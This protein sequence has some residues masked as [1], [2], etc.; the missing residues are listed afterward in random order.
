MKK[1]RHISMLIILGVFCLS[2]ATVMAQD[3]PKDTTKKKEKHKVSFKDSLDHAFDLSN[4]MIYAGGFVLVPV[5]ITEPALGGIG[6]ALVP[7]FLKQ[8]APLIDTVNGKVRIRRINPDI[9]GALAMYTANNSWMAG[10]FRGGTFAKPNITYRAMAAYGSLNLSFY[11][12]FPVIGEKE[13][14]F[15]FKVVPIYLQA[16][17][18][19]GNNNRWSAGIQYLFLDA[20]ISSKGDNMPDFVTSKEL[21]SI[22]SQ[23]GGVFQYD[24]RDNIF[25]PNKGVRLQADFFWSN[26]ILGSDY[27]SWQIDYSAIG[28]TPI[29]KKLIGG[30]RIEGQQSLGSPPFYTLPFVNLRGVPS[31]RYQGKATLQSEVETRWDFYKRWSAVFYGGTGVAY[32]KWSDMFANDLVYS[33][34][35][36]FRYLIARKFGLRMGADV[37]RG[38]EKWAYYIVF[39]SSW[40]R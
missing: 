39:G 23:V 9:T 30:L 36:G 11:H 28:Y 29:F 40:L 31:G 15:N 25:T 6:G 18:Q 24:S 1:L 16:L 14:K 5:P 38:P 13:F 17:K 19:F 26:S 37:A 12:T 33:Y 8:R 10:L 32:D 35:T 34:G 22:I 21:N 20:K 27:N 7:V 4:Y 3:A 2:V